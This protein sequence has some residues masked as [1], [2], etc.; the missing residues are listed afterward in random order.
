MVSV[1]KLAK[2]QFVFAMKDIWVQIALQRLAQM[3]VIIMGNVLMENVIA[4]VALQ[5]YP[6]KI[7]LA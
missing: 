1:N 5:E 7:K 6:A 2:K 4:K 3:I